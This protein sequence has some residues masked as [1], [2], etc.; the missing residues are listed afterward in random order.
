VAFVLAGG[1]ANKDFPEDQLAQLH[2]TTALLAS[3]NIPFP[4]N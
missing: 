3:K 2:A 4:K 1:Y